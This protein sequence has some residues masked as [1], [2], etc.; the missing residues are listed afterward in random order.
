[1]SQENQAPESAEPQMSPVEQEA[2]ESGWV[3]KEEYTGEEHKWV[4]AGEFLRRGELFK[5]IESQSK[6]L[7]DVKNAL[8]ELKKLQSNIREQEYKRA[9]ESL[10][11]Q[12]KTALQE[13]DVDAVVAAE[14]QIELVKQEQASFQTE[15]SKAPEAHPEFVAWS[16]RNSWYASSAPMRAFAD[17]VGREL[18]AAGNSP[19][20]VL[21]KV[22]AE[23]RKEFPNKFQNPNRSKPGAVESSAGT[24]TASSKSFALTDEERRVGNTFIRQGVFKNMDEYVAE[25]KKVRG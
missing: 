2:R 13:G 3:P 6:E 8:G 16:E 14:E 23:V 15:T 19:S 11:H 1:M 9:L 12:R 25:L 10:K 20:E 21:R 17:A 7:K 24:G 5:K 22:E 4:D 18:A